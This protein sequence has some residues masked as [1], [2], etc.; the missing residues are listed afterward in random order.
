MKTPRP[1][2]HYIIGKDAWFAVVFQWLGLG[3]LLEHG[4]YRKLI[5]SARRETKRK[6]KSRKNRNCKK[7][8]S[9]QSETLLLKRRKR[10]KSKIES[11]RTWDCRSRNTGAR[12]NRTES[13]RK[14]RI[15]N[16]GE[17][18]NWQTRT[19]E[20]RMPQGLRVQIPPRSPFISKKLSGRLAQWQSV[21]LTQRRPQVQTLHRP[22]DSRPVS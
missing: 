15:I 1:K 7:N 16:L 8:K 4:V 2:N 21:S 13:R 10:Q 20:V 14:K 9:A 6:K 19:L 12:N 3:E 5:R 11:E 18:R 22:L 17:W